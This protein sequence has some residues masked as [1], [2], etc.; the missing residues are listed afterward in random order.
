VAAVTLYVV[1][2]RENRKRDGLAVGETE[3][4]RLAFMDLTDKENRYFR[5]V[6]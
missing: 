2:L 6:L 3:R 5:Y 1:L 4:D